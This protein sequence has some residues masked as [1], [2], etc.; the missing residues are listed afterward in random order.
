MTALLASELDTAC[1]VHGVAAGLSDLGGDLALPKLA[2]IASNVEAALRGAGCQPDEP[3]AVF[4]SNRARDLGSLW[5][6]WKAG[7]VAAPLHRTSPPAVAELLVDRL[8]ARFIVDA[9]AQSAA[10]VRVLH[11]PV[12][13]TRPMLKDAALITFTSGTT[14]QPKGVVLSHAAIVGKLGANNSVLHFGVGTRTLLVLQIT[15]SF[16]MWVSLLTLTRG[17]WLHLEEKFE[18]RRFLAVLAAGRITDVALVPTMIRALLASAGEADLY[19]QVAG[20]G[21]LRHV[22]RLLTGGENLG[23]VLGQRLNALFPQAALIDIY[24]LTETATS[25]FFL[26]PQDQ[27]RYAGCIGRPGPGIVY[28]LADDQGRLVSQGE[29]GELQI[30]TPYLMNG[31]LDAPDLT[32]QALCEGFFRTG[33]IARERDSGVVELVG[34]SKELISRGGNKV[35]PLEIEHVLAGHSAVAEALATGVPDPVLGER[36]HA[37]VVL[38]GGSSVTE[39][40]LGAW[41]AERLDRY[42]LPDRI[43]FGSQLPQGP[44]GKSD[45]NRLRDLLSNG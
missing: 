7:A 8:A 23:P 44:T 39:A 13:P 34:R 31:Y 10:P 18:T 6:I 26:L 43:H 2:E 22:T 41:A 17:G 19:R 4:V 42:K 37:M 40:E 38:R 21:G 36:I 35:S 32:A 28:R 24:G 12:P 5:G 25:D 33:D 3:V 29:R 11:R 9:D 30:R 14:G 20:L 27:V 1:A 15:F 16:G 45:R